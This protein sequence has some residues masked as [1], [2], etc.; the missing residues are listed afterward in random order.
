MTPPNRF[1]KTDPFQ[2]R[3]VEMAISLIAVILGTGILYLPR[4]L[5]SDLNTPDGWITIILNGLLVMLVVFLYVR[6]QKHFPGQNLLQIIENQS[7]GKWPGQVL[8]GLYIIYFIL[9]LAFI[10]RITTVVLQ[11]YLL[12]QTPTIITGSIILLTTAYAVSKG[13]QGV[14]HLN[15]MFAPI[16]IAFFIIIFA[17]NFPDAHFQEILPILGEGIGPVFKG[18][19]HTPLV[20]LGVE[21]IFFFMAW[22]KS[23]EVRA[24]PLNV[25]I[26]FITLFN[27]ALTLL[28]YSIFGFQISKSITFPSIELAKELEIPGAFFERI[29]SLVITLWMMSIFNT[30]STFHLL[31]VQ[32][33]REQFLPRGNTAWITSGVTFI[34]FMLAFIFPSISEAFLFGGVIMFLGVSLIISSLI[35]GY[36]ARWTTSMHNERKT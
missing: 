1:Q 28:G 9:A 8:R 20:F 31:A 15:I 21:I 16:S 12:L 23:R 25:S 11:I 3:G 7:W 6:L 2:I 36:L 5:A 30:I 24:L 4:E 10:L 13:T 33:I 26:G 32:N 17:F 34:I 19:K 29:E 22:M 14:I 27:V 18:F 35:C